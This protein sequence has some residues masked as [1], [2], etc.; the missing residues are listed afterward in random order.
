MPHPLHPSPRV[1]YLAARLAD[2]RAECR[3]YRAI[4]D[5]RMVGFCAARCGQYLRA[6]RAAL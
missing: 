2:A 4:G 3:R 1:R 5:G 6:L